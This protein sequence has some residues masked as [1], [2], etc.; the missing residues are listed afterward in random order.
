MAK[1]HTRPVKLVELA[2]RAP[3]AVP[4]IG[5]KSTPPNTRTPRTRSAAEYRHVVMGTAPSV[6]L[7][8]TASAVDILPGSKLVNND[9]TY[10]ARRVS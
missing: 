7:D 1:T 10:D 3:P 4:V 9:M 8:G 5:R 6:P 2:Y